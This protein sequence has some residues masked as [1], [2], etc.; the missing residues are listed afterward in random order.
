MLKTYTACKPNDAA[1][2]SLYNVSIEDCLLKQNRGKF[3]MATVIVLC[4]MTTR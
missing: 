1:F 2:R 3:K 4:Q